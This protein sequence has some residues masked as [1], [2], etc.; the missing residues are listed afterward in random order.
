MAR[1][2]SASQ[3][4]TTTC[5]GKLSSIRDV[6]SRRRPKLHTTPAKPIV[7]ITERQAKVRFESEVDI[8]E[9]PSH[10]DYSK[11]EKQ[12]IWMPR[13]ELKRLILKNHAE[14]AY[15]GRDWRNA[16]EE[17]DFGADDN[18]NPLHPVHFI[19]S[20]DELTCVKRSRLGQRRISISPS[21]CQDL[22]QEYRRENK[23][24]RIEYQID[25]DL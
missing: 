9:I 8:Y 25:S 23:R 19:R 7:V 15:E 11:E 14:Y 13:Y 1:C 21:A 3:S 6:Y 5:G 22:G 17:D 16:P 24:P 20:L 10:N 4:T 12:E 18:G 2:D